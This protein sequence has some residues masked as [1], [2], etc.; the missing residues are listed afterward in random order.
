MNSPDYLSKFGDDLV[1]LARL[2]LAGRTQDVR[3]LLRRV[4]RRYRSTFPTVSDQLLALLRETPTRSSPL[5]NAASASI[6]V[7]QDSRLQL[8]RHEFV[9]DLEVEPIFSESVRTHLEQLVSE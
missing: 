9:A 2:A 7:D 6:P 4:A 3:L 5:R 8:M 1:H